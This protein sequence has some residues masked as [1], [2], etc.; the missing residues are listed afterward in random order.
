[1]EMLCPHIR[2]GE[3]ARELRTLV[4]RAMPGPLSA[5]ELAL[6]ASSAAVA[7]VLVRLW[8]R[9]IV[10]ILFAQRQRQRALAA[11]EP[12]ILDTTVST[13]ALFRRG[14]VALIKRDIEGAGLPPHVVDYVNK[15]LIARVSE[16]ISLARSP[17][18]HCVA[19]PVPRAWRRGS[20]HGC[21]D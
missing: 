19:S 6:C 12:C 18:Q 1:M 4:E 10:P 3:F 9:A 13:V 14:G 21:S 2:P 5:R 17:V 20:M 7:V 8:D 16:S 11:G 15:L